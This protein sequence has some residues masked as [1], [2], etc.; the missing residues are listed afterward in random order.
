MPTARGRDVAATGW[1]GMRARVQTGA[2]ERGGQ[3]DSMHDGRELHCLLNLQI[4]TET[5]IRGVW[6]PTAMWR[7][8]QTRASVEGCESRETQSSPETGR[9]APHVIQAT[10]SVRDPQCPV[11]WTPNSTCSWERASCW[12]AAMFNPRTSV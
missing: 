9:E 8:T 1:S 7:C 5:H 10:P 4:N 3:T 12:C 6:Q 11:K 2:A